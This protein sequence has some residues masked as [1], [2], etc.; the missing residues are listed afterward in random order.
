VELVEDHPAPSVPLRDRIY[1]NGRWQ[2]SAG[3]E[4]IEVHGAATGRVIG[5]IPRGTA[6]DVD[7]AV[8]SASEAFSAWSALE[9]DD[10]LGLLAELAAALHRRAPELARLITTEVG[11]PIKIS[12]MLQVEPPIRNL[13]GLPTLFESLPLSERVGESLVLR[14]PIGV[15]AAITAWNYPL[16]QLLGKVGAALA[17]GCTVVVKPSEVAP[18]SAFVVADLVDEVGFPA[19]VFNLLSG[20]GT[21]VGE[22]LAAHAGVDMVTFT[23]STAT[24]RRIGEVAARTVKR[25]AL[26]LGGKSACVILDD[27]DLEQAVKVGIANCFTNSGQTCTALTRMLVPIGLLAEVEDLVRAR[28]ERYRVGDPMDRTTTLGPLASAS[29]RERVRDHIRR[30]IAEGATVVSGGA[31]PPDGL[32]DECSG[33]YFVCPTA[34]S[35]VRADATIATEEIFGPVLSIIPYRDENEAVEIANSTIYG[36]AGAVWSQDPGRA[37]RVA[38]RM[39]TGAVDI[40]GSFFNPMAPFGGYRQSGIGREMG[41][42]GLHEFLELKAVQGHAS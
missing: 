7:V 8:A 42:Y 31:E 23:G 12:E 33:G 18:L 22:R 24:G 25:T 21:E 19:G 37:N 15:V 34:F 14:E 27:A 41:T 9:L 32:P 30:G 10:R 39:R 38:R 17:T 20:T 35:R 29:Q 11:T 2:P 6:A 28:L 36:L 13:A 26:E 1:V 3:T 4:G 16:Q 5:R 40:N